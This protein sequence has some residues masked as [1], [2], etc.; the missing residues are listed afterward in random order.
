[1][2]PNSKLQQQSDSNVHSA[3]SV[4]LISH[5]RDSKRRTSSH[6]GKATSRQWFVS[7]RKQV[8]ERTSTMNPILC[9]LYAQLL[10]SFAH[11]SHPLLYVVARVSRSFNAVDHPLD[12]RPTIEADITDS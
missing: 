11:R 5:T 9:T 3:K 10:W 6:I 8:D 7:G 1:M 12:A 4:V 2:N